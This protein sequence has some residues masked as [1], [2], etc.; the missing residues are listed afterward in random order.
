MRYDVGSAMHHGHYVAALAPSPLLARAA[1]AGAAVARTPRSA[2]AAPA[3][4]ARV[5]LRGHRAERR[6]HPQRR[7]GRPREGDRWS[8]RRRWATSRTPPSTSSTCRSA[9]S[10]T[11][12]GTGF[13]ILDPQTHQLEI[14]TAA[15][16]VLR[17]DRLKLT[18]RGGQT[19]DGDGR[20]H[21]RGARRRH[22]RA[23]RAA[24]GRAAARRSPTPIPRSA[25]PVWAMGHTGPGLLGALV[26]H[27]PGHR[28]RHRRDVRRE[29][30]ALRRGGV[31]RLLRAAPWSTLG[32]DGKPRV[33]GVNHAI[34]FTG[35]T[36]LSPLGPIS[37]A[38]SARA[39]SARSTLGHPPP[40]EATMAAYAKEQRTKQ[41]ADIFVDRP[42]ERR[43][44][45]EDQPVAAI[46]GNA[47]DGR[48]RA[49][50]AAC[51]S[52]RWPCSSGSARARTT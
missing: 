17:P 31:P 33:V 22:P 7:P 4:T 29:A 27:E 6:R 18:T 32:P 11:P 10:P 19:V 34:L 26:G 45:R 8:S 37:S 13:A 2:Q 28:V 47:N 14:V 42:P 25:H 40:M 24:Q 35:A 49:T 51:A 30:P 9:R 12:H 15:H 52:R 20:A 44:R 38:V 3:S 46:Y 36:L 23:Q 50:T 41:W 5:R 39:S 48:R 43:A 1:S 21:R 16:V